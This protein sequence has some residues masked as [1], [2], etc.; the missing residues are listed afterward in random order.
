MTRAPERRRR[1][2]PPRDARRHDAIPTE[3][4][5]RL[6]AAG[7][8]HGSA[9]D[10]QLAQADPLA[11][12][13][14]D[15]AV[16]AERGAGHQLDVVTRELEPRPDVR[17]ERVERRAQLV[18]RPAQRRGPGRGGE[19]PLVLEQRVVTALTHRL[20]DP[21]DPVGDRARRRQVR[22]HLGRDG[23]GVAGREREPLNHRAA[24]PACAPRGRRAPRP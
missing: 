9:R 7:R 5:I 22:A 6:P 1:R 19:A 23:G 16:L 8:V 10:R 18:G 21:R 4:R 17:V 20:D 15:V 14:L 12:R 11:L 24:P 13:Q 3:G 2:P